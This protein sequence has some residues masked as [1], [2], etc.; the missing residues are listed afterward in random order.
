[1]TTT[2]PAA[3][4]DAVVAA[5]NTQNV[6]FLITVHLIVLAIVPWYAFADT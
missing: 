2:T 1:M 3:W 4:H 6:S 5:Q